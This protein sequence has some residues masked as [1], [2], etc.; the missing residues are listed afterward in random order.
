[1]LSVLLTIATSLTGVNNTQY[2]ELVHLYNSTGGANWSQNFGWLVGDYCD[3]WHGVVCNKQGDVVSLRLVDNNLDGDYDGNWDAFQELELLDLSENSQLT[4]DIGSHLTTLPSSLM[5]LFLEYSSFSGTAVFDDVICENRTETQKVKISVANNNITSLS[6]V[7]PDCVYSMDY[8]N[9]ARASDIPDIKNASSLQNLFLTGCN[10]TAPKE[11]LSSL[12]DISSLVKVNLADNQNLQG[13][14]DMLN[15]IGKASNLRSL[16]ISNTKISGQFPEGLFNLS[17]LEDLTLSGDFS[18]KL[19]DNFGNMAKLSS[20]SLVGNFTGEFPGSIF[21]GAIEYVVI[22]HTQLSGTLPSILPSL[23]LVNVVLDNNRLQGTIPP[24][25]WTS[26]SKELVLSNNKFVGTIPTELQNRTNSSDSLELVELSNNLLSGF[27][28]SFYNDSSIRWMGADSSEKSQFFVGLDLLKP[29]PSW[30]QDL[31]GGEGRFLD[32]TSVSP[33]LLPSDT[34][35]D[36]TLSGDLVWLPKNT[37]RIGICIKNE[38]NPCNAPASPGYSIL[39]L[40][41]VSET[42]YTFVVPPRVDNLTG[43]YVMN[44]FYAPVD[45]LPSII[46]NYTSPATGIVYNQFPKVSHV[47]PRE[48]RSAGCWAVTVV[49]TGFT[50]TLN[51]LLCEYNN[52]HT[53]ATYVNSTTV[54]CHI[55]KTVVTPLLNVNYSITVTPNNG[56]TH[57]TPVKDG[58]IMFVQSC[59]VTKMSDLTCDDGC[60]LCP[61][62]GSYHGT[63]DMSILTKTYICKCSGEFTGAACDACDK[64]HFGEFCTPCISCDQGSCNDGIDGDGKCKC[65]R[66]YSGEQCDKVCICCFAI[67]SFIESD[68]VSYQ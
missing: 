40:T 64:N 58:E 8:S 32:I 53:R 24:S 35:S 52:T 25:M 4:G 45:E 13:S 15:C 3:Q 57:S 9:N 28:P 54:L 66:L 51:N 37:L 46:N 26:V 36:V 31:G 44:V 61:C 20:L 60:G 48:V 16:V 42:M 41:T 19:S 55:P 5:N 27:V 29:V 34:E 39:P 67:I 63:C 23:K 30:V 17:S 21:S 65:S 59:P 33:M 11:W 18:G 56:T 68:Y 6:G 43:S 7:I 50:D 38:T 2:A 49:G 47:E 1:M 12:C 62:S 10:A 22:E 14:T